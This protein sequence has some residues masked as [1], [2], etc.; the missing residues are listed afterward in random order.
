MPVIKI[1]QTRTINDK[2]TGRD[3]PPLQDAVRSATWWNRDVWID[4]GAAFVASAGVQGVMGIVR[5]ASGGRAW[6]GLV[7]KAVESQFGSWRCSLVWTTNIVAGMV[8]RGRTAEGK[9]RT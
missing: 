1:G 8:F 3:G 5:V 2:G 4:A 9:V 7:A 6:L